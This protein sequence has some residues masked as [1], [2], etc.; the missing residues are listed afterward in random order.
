[1]LLM[2][3]SDRAR[4]RRA[5]AT[6]GAGPRLGAALARLAPE[7]APGRSS[8]RLEAAARHVAAHL[9]PAGALTALGAI[10]LTAAASGLAASLAL[11]ATLALAAALL[12][13]R[14]LP[15]ALLAAGLAALAALLA[16]LVEALA[17]RLHAARQPA[18]AGERFGSRIALRRGDRASGLAELR[19]DGVDVSADLLLERGG[20]VGRRALHK[21]P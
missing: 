14:L 9:L 7:L 17:H 11:L 3:A 8:R 1:M 12:S 18:R 16:L 6:R 13:C 19:L 15:P 20:L 21:A 2:S 10:A 4:R 5:P